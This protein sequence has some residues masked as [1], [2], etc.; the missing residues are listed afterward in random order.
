MRNLDQICLVCR[1]SETV[2]KALDDFFRVE[3]DC[4]YCGKYSIT[5]NAID[6]LRKFR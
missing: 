1:E 6:D 2:V 4:A 5:E 3:V